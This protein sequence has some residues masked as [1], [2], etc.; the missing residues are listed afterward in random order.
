M[1]ITI[2]VIRVGARPR[3]IHFM[4]HWTYEFCGS[5]YFGGNK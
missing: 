2:R 5:L 3:V 1:V 4:N